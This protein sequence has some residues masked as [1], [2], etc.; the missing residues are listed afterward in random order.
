MPDVTQERRIAPRY[1]L[2]LSAEITEPASGAKVMART[3]DISRSGCYLDTPKP[4]SQRCADTAAPDPWRRSV[5]DGGSRGLRQPRAGYGC[6]ISGA[7]K[8]KSIGR[9]GP[10]AW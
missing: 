8:R 3:S 7:S 10:L 2:V 1:P 5:R 4:H 9:F 6:E